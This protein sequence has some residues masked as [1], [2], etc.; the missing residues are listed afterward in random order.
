M[1]KCVNMIWPDLCNRY[2]RQS[3]TF[4]YA[5]RALRV[6]ILKVCRMNGFICNL[7]L[8]AALP[9]ASREDLNHQNIQSLTNLFLL[10]LR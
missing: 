7:W 4:E 10:E 9:I 5:L 6:H 1:K 3:R 8:L 2:N